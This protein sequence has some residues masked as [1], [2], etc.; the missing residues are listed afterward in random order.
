MVG[1]RGPSLSIFHVTVSCVFVVTVQQIRW[2]SKD[3]NSGS[4]TPDLHRPPKHEKNITLD[5]IHVCIV[6]RIVLN[7]HLNFKLAHTCTRLLQINIIK[8]NT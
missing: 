1:K 2:H 3:T 6:K 8:K 7:S 4:C 5:V